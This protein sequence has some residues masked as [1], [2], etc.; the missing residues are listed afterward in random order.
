VK[1]ELE[2]K[3]IFITGFMGVGKT[4][5]AKELA[6][7]LNCLSLDLDQFI[8]EHEGRS[9]QEIID[10]EGEPRFR[11]LETSYLMR[12]IET[13]SRIIA[14]G[15]GAWTIEA[16]RDIAAANGLSIWLDAPFELCWQRIES[17]GNVRP[18]AR[19]IKKAQERYE[20]RK[21]FYKLV[22][23]RVEVTAEKSPEMLANEIIEKLKDQE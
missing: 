23:L 17:T 21:Q 14:L 2:S 16:N 5:V 12:T 15:G 3:R 9:P 18:F 13:N 7:S 11:E 4:T 20:Y 1:I 8:E 22:S 6:N 19:D 10:N